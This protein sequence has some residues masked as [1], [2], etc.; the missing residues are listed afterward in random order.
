M[1]P[2]GPQQSVLQT[3]ILLWEA[4]SS[5]R[6]WCCKALALTSSCTRSSSWHRSASGSCWKRCCTKANWDLRTCRSFLSTKRPEEKY[7]NYKVGAAEV[8]TDT[9]CD[10]F[11]ERGILYVFWC[12]SCITLTNHTRISCFSTRHLCENIKLLL[13]TLGKVPGLN[14]AFACLLKN[15]LKAQ[16]DTL[17]LQRA[18][19]SWLRLWT[20]LIC[21][22]VMHS[23]PRS[24]RRVIPWSKERE[25]CCSLAFSPGLSLRCLPSTHCWEMQERHKVKGKFC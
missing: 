3:W 18:A 5:S 8:K 24:R 10:I 4:T 6:P 15:L 7:N 12:H 1:N 17:R 23:S 16:W 13:H 21:P 19:W 20:R 9:A 14:L 2:Y 25:A 11:I 22:S